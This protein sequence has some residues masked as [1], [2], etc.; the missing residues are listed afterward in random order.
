VS[1][2]GGFSTRQ[3]YTDADEVFFAATRP[4]ILNG[5]DYVADRP[6]LADRALILNLP[7]I[8]EFHRREEKDLYAEFENELPQVLGALY[9]AVSTALVRLPQVSLAR[10]PRMA[11][12]A[13]WAVAGA[14][15]LG[16]APEE[17]LD[18]YCGNRADAVHET[19]DGDPVAVAI[20]A[21][22]DERE[23][24]E[25]TD[26]WEGNCKALLASLEPLTAEGVK[27]SHHWP[28]TPRALSG[29]LRRLVTFLRESGIE[30]SFCPRGSKGKRPLTIERKWSHS[31]ATTATSDSKEAPDHGDTAERPNGGMSS[32]VEDQSPPSEEPS[33]QPASVNPLKASGNG[34]GEAVVAEVTVVCSPDLESQAFGT[35]ANHVNVCPHCG[36]VEWRWTNGVWVCPKCGEPAPGQPHRAERERIEL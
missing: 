10:K 22:M 8:D 32:G 6:D 31:T 36:P 13:V 4:I 20:S 21:L 16:F 34:G 26:V 33:P 14:P 23:R 5:I 9:D 29:R 7:R 35:A 27:R 12:F 18:A 1:T 2:G 17:F 15:A 24:T 25:G 30:I 3:L 28:K 19:L 11:D